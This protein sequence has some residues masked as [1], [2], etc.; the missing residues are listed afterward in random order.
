[1]NQ[2]WPPIRFLLIGLLGTLAAVVVIWILLVVA[3]VL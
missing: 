1:M 2:L 3:G